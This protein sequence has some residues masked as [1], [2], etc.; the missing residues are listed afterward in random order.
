[1]EKN[2]KGEVQKNKTFLALKTNGHLNF[3][4][5]IR[6]FLKNFSFFIGYLE[7]QKKKKIYRNNLIM[8]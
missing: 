2:L 8:V 5:E 6:N 7:Y 4:F 1:M 3:F